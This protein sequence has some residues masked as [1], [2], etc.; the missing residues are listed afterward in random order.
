MTYITTCDTALLSGT[1]PTPSTRRGGGG[2]LGM[3]W[4]SESDAEST[5]EIT[6]QPVG[7]DVGKLSADGEEESVGKRGIK[8]AAKRGRLGG[9]S[10][11]GMECTATTA[12]DAANGGDDDAG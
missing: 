7:I 12:D 5:M 2:L 3:R 11:E 1:T 10:G 8:R 9:S 6:G 4:V